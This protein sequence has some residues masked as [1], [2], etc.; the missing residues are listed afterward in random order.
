MYMYIKHYTHWDQ[1]TVGMRVNNLSSGVV[2]CSP[3]GRGFS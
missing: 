3:Q 2:L 1:H